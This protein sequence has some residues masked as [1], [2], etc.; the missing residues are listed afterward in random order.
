M[1]ESKAWENLLELCMRMLCQS[2]EGLHF[3]GRLVW[4]WCHSGDPQMSECHWSHNYTVELPSSLC[5][6]ARGLATDSSE[7][8]I[9]G[10][11]RE[12]FQFCA[13]CSPLP[14]YHHVVSHMASSHSWARHFLS[15]AFPCG[16]TG[17]A[18]SLLRFIPRRHFLP[19]RAIITSLPRTCCLPEFVEISCTLTVLYQSLICCR[20][21][22]R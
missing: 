22:T 12:Y 16:F 2:T 5:L 6:R 17:S 20:S 7:T 3:N 4:S 21:R 10:A 1:F 9:G 14:L 18:V 11:G 8:R 15:P 19:P 13:W